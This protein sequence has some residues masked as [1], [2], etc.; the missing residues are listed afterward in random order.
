[1]LV[2]E[3]LS[4]VR[5]A[6]CDTW[7][8]V[9]EYF[10]N[11]SHENKRLEELKEELTHNELREGGWLSWDEE[12][13]R[14]SLTNGT[15]RFAAAVALGWEDFPVEVEVEIK[16]P[17]PTSYISTEVLIATTLTDV[18][19]CD[20]LMY[21]AGSSL[22]FALNSETWVECGLVSSRGTRLGQE[23]TFD[24]DLI[25]DAFEEEFALKIL[26]RVS[27]CLRE[28]AIEYYTV[29]RQ[30]SYNKSFWRN[31]LIRS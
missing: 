6:Y 17:E 22:S 11:D 21:C 25:P 19:E 16:T 4:A 23:F 30:H 10:N 14:Y 8:G 15:H 3:I 13:A 26:Q 24:F 31:K 1:M 29:A 20:A 27:C 9:F 5:P 12:D 7:E 18:E 2:S 28:D